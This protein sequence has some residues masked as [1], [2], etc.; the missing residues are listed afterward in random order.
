MTKPSSIGLH[1]SDWHYGEVIVP[2]KVDGL[3]NINIKIL[4]KRVKDTVFKALELLDHN[5]GT[6]FKDFHL[7]Y[8]GDMVSGE[9]HAEHAETNDLGIMEQLELV[10]ND[11]GWATN[12]IAEWC[13]R[14]SIPLFV[15]CVA[16]N[17]GD[18]SEGH[19]S[20]QIVDRNLDWG[21]YWRAASET[22]PGEVR[23]N[24]PE[25][26]YTEFTASGRLY[27][28]MHGHGSKGGGSAASALG[29]AAPVLRLDMRTRKMAASV[30][31]RRCYDTLIAGHHHWYWTS[32]QVLGNG[33]LI[34]YNE[35]ALACGFPYQ[36]PIQTLWLTHPTYGITH[37]MPVHCTS[38]A[39]TVV[40]G[41]KK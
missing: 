17:H 26:L 6:E 2:E 23:W 9:R 35:Y 10:A 24:I 31:D 29:P 39:S 8:G 34:G 36:P 19:P 3:N 40:K 33:S 22:Y 16:G 14:K 41:W 12:E 20:K 38:S 25:G 15:H 21:A 11:I 18:L 4:R 1:L 30:S 37:Y 27:R 5:T 7:C 32:E 28:L 13:A